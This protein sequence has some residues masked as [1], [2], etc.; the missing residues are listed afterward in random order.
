MKNF[1]EF[2]ENVIVTT[3]Q[4]DFSK[5]SMVSGAAVGHKDRLK[6]GLADDNHP[7]DFDQKELEM[8]IKIEMEHTNDRNKAQEI[9]MDH[10][11]EIPDYYTR[12]KKME[13]GAK[14]D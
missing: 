7:S 11:K 12:L 1:K 5:R 2:Y 3:S 6:G 10:L 8:G 4:D 9:A 14:K 13:A